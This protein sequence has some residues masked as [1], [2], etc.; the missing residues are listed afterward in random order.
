MKPITKASVEQT[1][2]LKIIGIITMVIDHV[3][4]VFHPE[5]IEMQVIGRLCYP[6]FAYLLVIG[7][8]HTSN[9]KQ[10]AYRI[11]LFAFISQPLFSLIFQTYILN[12]L[13]T[14]L[15]GLLSL[16]A[17]S[18]RYWI[19]YV[20]LLA[21]STLDIMEYGLQGVLLINFIYVFRNRPVLA[22]FILFFHFGIQLFIDINS[23][24]KDLILNSTLLITPSP[25]LDVFGLI[26]LLLIYWRFS[27]NL[28]LPKNFYYLFYPCHLLLLLIASKVI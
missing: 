9:W 17:I 23:I 22:F 25:S 15:I 20:L 12:V 1:D 6:I 18:R 5:I 28:W 7:F 26:S 19:T 2:T 3:G 13:F 27:W 10:Y 11:A 14:L 16:L 4:K 21:I 8:L 24:L